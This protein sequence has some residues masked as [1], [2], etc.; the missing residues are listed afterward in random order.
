MKKVFIYGLCGEDGII[1][2]VGKSYN[3]NK[4]KNEHISDSINGRCKN[5]HKNNWIKKLINRNEDINVVI[6]E[7]CAEDTWI[8]KE[9]LWISKIEK[10]T[11]ITWGGEG[12]SGSRFDRSYNDIKNWVINNLPNI[13]TYKQWRNYITNNNLPEF[14][15]KRPDAVYKN[16]GWTNYEDFFDNKSKFLNYFSLKDIV[17]SSNIKSKSE[18]IKFRK[19]NM[20][21]N[22]ESIYEDFISW[23][24]FLGKTTKKV[25]KKRKIFLSYCEAKKVIKKFNFTK[26]LEY[27]EWFL[28][29]KN[30]GLPRDP[31]T[32]YKNEWVSWSD[33]FGNNLPKKINYK[34][35]QKNKKFLNYDECKKW[36]FENL[37]VKNEIEWRKLTK[38]LPYFIPKRPDFVFKDI[39]KGYKD[40]LSK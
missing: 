33:F 19:N 25:I 16:K 1:R 24:D 38:D 32:F 13:K 21:Y 35:A 22:P 8:E 27:V 6:L 11:N 36:V 26:K 9:K 12:N 15:P 23:N 2:Y 17:Q 14:V 28:K 37:N 30:I 4:R 7:E 18:Y 29:N 31:I 3:V 20:P 40:F 5:K 10:L 34:G 39:W